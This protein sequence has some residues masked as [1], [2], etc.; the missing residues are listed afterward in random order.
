MK[1]AAAA[2]ALGALLSSTVHANPKPDVDE[3]YPYTGPAVPVGDW[4]D[5]D[6]NGNGKGFPRLVEPPA[7]TPASDNPTNNV[8]VIALSYVPEGINIH[9]QTP[10]GLGADPSVKWGSDAG[11]LGNTATGYSH[12]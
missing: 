5:Q 12:T 10:F 8:N 1:S 3:S 9:Y 2:L 6:A 11:S 7:V 4:A